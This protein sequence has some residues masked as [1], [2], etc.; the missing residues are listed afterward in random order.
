M[1]Q[2]IPNSTQ[3]PNIILDFLLPNLPEA[4]GK[5]LLYICRRTFGFQ[6]ESDRISFS[7]FENGIKKEDKILDMGTGLSRPTISGALAN[8]GEAQAIFSRK[9]SKGNLYKINLEMNAEQV[10][11]KINQLRILTKSG[12]KSKPKQVKLF[13]S[14]YTGKQ[15]E[16]NICKNFEKPVDELWTEMLDPHK[17]KYAPALVTAFENHWRQKNKNCKELWQME[18]V[19]DMGRRLET[20]RG[21]EER[22]AFERQA[23]R[24]VLREAETPRPQRER[25]ESG[26]ERVQFANN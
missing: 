8:L 22:W 18:K 11:K 20:W 23:K 1:S 25:T 7:Q 26:F 9:S 21:N 6:K 10:V 14:Q 13:N 4:E 19:F 17:N 3:I 12:K 15:R 24:G 16:S 2:F 5:C